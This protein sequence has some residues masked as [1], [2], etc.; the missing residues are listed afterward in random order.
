MAAMTG[1]RWPIIGKKVHPE[2]PYIDAEIRY[3]VR[4]YACTAV[5]MIARRLRLAFLNVQAASE[6]LPAIA[7]IMAEELKWSDAEK[8]RQIKMA[9]D[10]LAAE[11][12][13]MVN[14]A[15][16]D[17]IPINLSK[18]EIQTYIK[19]FQIIDK[20]RKGYV[21]IN[22]IR[23]SLKSMGLRPSDAEISSILSEIDV[24]YHGQ[25]E[26]QDYLQVDRERGQCPSRAIC[27][28]EGVNGV[29][30][31]IYDLHL[32]FEWYLDDFAAESI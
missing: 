20:D 32:F 16:R 31:R 6:A 26:I 29:K 5:D 18:D 8:A 28:V 3:G 2:F 19:R 24:T 27:V 9:N 7:D 12:G 25:M 21:S 1:K 11:M 17:K 14:R 4:E 30:L 22:D 13:Q 10:F 23:R 15:S